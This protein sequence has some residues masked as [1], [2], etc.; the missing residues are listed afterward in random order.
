M[1]I[2][3][4]KESLEKG[5]S[6]YYTGKPCKHGHISERTTGDGGCIDC[7]FIKQKKYYD[8]NRESILKKRSESGYMRQYYLANKGK[9]AEQTKD[10][11]ERNSDI[12]KQR[13]A[14]YYRQNK[15]AINNRHK[16]YW[17]ENKEKILEK[18]REKYHSLSADEKAIMVSF[19]VEWGRKNKDKR[20][21]YTKKW[22]Q[23]NKHKVLMNTRARQNCI[24]K[25]TPDWACLNSIETKYKE[26][27]TMSKVTGIVHHVDHIIPLQGEN[28]CGL[29]V[30][31]NL[32]VI[33]ARDNLRK[34]NKLELR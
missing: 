4:R 19:S 23:N 29:H 8:E 26:R 30:H 14:N 21:K 27:E 12:I 28:V 1:E 24:S 6:R 25:A 18:E 9:I 10:Y 33:P 5:L 13:K 2:I 16:E 7:S 15:E 11:R 32:R 31:N 22:R 3:T 20:K 34:S 17:L